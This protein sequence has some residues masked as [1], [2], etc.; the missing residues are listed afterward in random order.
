MSGKRC[1]SPASASG[2]SLASSHTPSVPVSTR[3]RSS[4]RRASQSASGTMTSPRAGT[5]GNSPLGPRSSRCQLSA[6]MR[7]SLISVAIYGFLEGFDADAVHHVDEALGVAVAPRE[8][9]VDQLLDHVG[10]L[11]ASE[12]GADDLAEGCAPAGPDFTLIAPD[13]DLVPLLAALVDAEYA[14]VADVMVAAGVHAPGDIEVDLADIVQVVEIVEALL[15]CLGHRDRL[16]VGERT[17]VPARAADDVSE[18]ADIG[19]GES[20]FLYLLPQRAQIG[21]L[22]VGKDQVL[23]VGYAQLAERIAVGEVGDFFHLLDGDIAGRHTGLLQRQRHCGIP[24]FLVRMDVALVPARERPLGRKR[25]LEPGIGRR[26]PQVARARK[27]AFDAGDLLGNERRGT[28]FQVRPFGIDFLAEFLGAAFFHQDL[29]A[30]LVDVVAPPVAVV[31]PQ[32]GLDVSEQMPPG[33]KFA[34]DESDRRSAAKASSDQHAEP[35]LAVLVLEGVQSDVVH[36]DRRTIRSCAVHGELEL[37]RKVGELGMERG[38]L[39]DDLAPH[40]GIDDLVLRDAG[41]MIG[42][43][44]AEGIARGLDRVHLH[45]GEL[46]EDV[47]RLRKLRPV[48]LEVLSRA[49]MAVAAVVFAGDMRELPQLLRRQQPVRDRDPEHRRVTLDVEAVPEAQRAKLI[50][51]ELAGEKAPRLVAELDDALVDELLVD[52]V[53]EIHEGYNA[54]LPP[55]RI[56]IAASAPRSS[57]SGIFWLS[58]L[59]SQMPGS[60]PM[61]RAPSSFQSTAPAA[62]WPSPATSVSGTAWAMSV[63]TIRATAR[64]G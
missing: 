45:G 22:H 29:D 37:A 26:Q 35:H 63:P 28:V 17:E 48:Q 15:N 34:D 54:S 43:D 55:I 6:T 14:D 24:R 39:A 40:K 62:A 33:Q 59:P 11:G 60:E 10:D 13:L 56:S 23:L 32:D 21:Q 58:A 3:E 52:F 8:I 5:S 36:G 61:R 18:Q 30:R 7:R 4:S 42:G 44:I 25:S 31:D 50:V 51:G 2:P 1:T 12:R 53:V 9:A 49:E 19:R 64:L 47:G 27:P 38:P 41:E 46:G 57:R 16:G 20:Q